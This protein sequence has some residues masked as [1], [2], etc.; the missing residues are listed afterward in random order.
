MFI[1]LRKQLV[2]VI[3]KSLSPFFDG[4]ALPVVEMDVPSEK[5]HGDFSTNIALKSVKL[6]KRPPM[7]VAAS[8]RDAIFAGL[9]EAG[10]KDK[11]AAIEVLKPGFINFFLS[12]SSVCEIL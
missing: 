5:T 4:V 6:L 8:F 10:L 3:E 11:I 7:D 1:S 2:C 12:T 9:K